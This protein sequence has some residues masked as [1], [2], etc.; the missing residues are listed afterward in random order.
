M[1]DMLLGWMSL[2][3]CDVYFFKDLFDLLPFLRA[4]HLMSLM[5]SPVRLRRHE[6]FQYIRCGWKKPNFFV[7]HGFTFRMMM[8]T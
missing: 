4:I 6:A 5:S 2:R 8:L 7:L 1:M 3:E